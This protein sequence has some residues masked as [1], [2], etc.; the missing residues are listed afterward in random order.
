MW[1]AVLRRVDAALCGVG[2]PQGVAAKMGWF[3]VWGRKGSDFSRGFLRSHTA[4]KRR[5]GFSPGQ[6]GSEGLPLCC[7]L[8]SPTSILRAVVAAHLHAGW[9]GLPS[10]ANPRAFGFT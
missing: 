3:T 10:L 6:R 5:G 2:V 4:R 7:L 8:L 1:P 9:E